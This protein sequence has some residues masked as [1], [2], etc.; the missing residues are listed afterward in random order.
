[1]GEPKDKTIQVDDIQIT[2]TAT[3]TWP[4]T[5]AASAAGTALTQLEA[6]QLKEMDNDN[7]DES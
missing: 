1:M 3:V 7:S 2:G 4:D 5:P 6:G